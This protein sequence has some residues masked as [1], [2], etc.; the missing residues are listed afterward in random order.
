MKSI[1]KLSALLLAVLM[2]VTAFGTT[3]VYA[4]P[5]INVGITATKVGDTVEVVIAPE[6]DLA[7]AG[8]NLTYTYDRTAF[9]FA[10]CTTPVANSVV[11]NP[12]TGLITCDRA[13]NVIIPAGEPLIKIVFNTTDAYNAG[14]EYAFS[15]NFAEA[16][17]E[18]IE[19]YDWI[20]SD[21]TVTYSEE[22]PAESDVEIVVT[23]V[24]DT[25]EVT[26]VPTVDTALAGINLV[27]TYDR[28][29]F[30]FVSCSSPIASSVIHNPET[31]LI[32][33]DRAENVIVA[34]GSPIVTIV[35]NFAE[36]YVAGTE[37]TFTAI[38]S[39]A[40]DENIEPYAWVEKMLTGTYK[41]DAPST[42]T[43]TWKVEGQEDVTTTVNAGEMPEYPNGTPTKEGN[44]QYTYTFTG[45]DP[46]VVPANADATYTAVFAETV[47]KYTVTFVDGLTEGV[48]T[49]V[50]VEYG[51]AATAP[52][53]PEHEGYT[54]IG[55]DPEDFTN[56][57]ADL[58]VT[59]TYAINK[60]TVTFVDGLTEGV[61]TTVE[62]E[63]G[64]AATAPAAPEHEGYTFIGW[65]PENFTNI[66]ANLTV[67]ATYAINKYT[68]T[69]VDGLTEEVITT[70][71]VEHGAAATAPAAPEHEGYTFIGWNP[72]DFSEVTENMTVTAM[73]EEI[74]YTPVAPTIAAQGAELRARTTEDGKK[75]VRF[76]FEVTF[77]D[78]Y[79]N[80]KG[81][82]YGPTTDYYQITD[83]SVDLKMDNG[84]TNTITA[85]SI[86]SMDK[87]N[88]TYRVT[89][90]VKGIPEDKFDVEFSLVPT[91]TYVMGETT[92]TATCDALKTT[93]N[94]VLNQ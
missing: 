84:T 52:A 41:E 24:G 3:A 51:A 19:N 90:V 80:Y 67:T 60:Y 81:K 85:N 65:D 7:V 88:W 59:A 74:P 12:A 56:I 11:H 63:H 15:V 46:E 57:T 64:A 29:A 45:W 68:V 58:T 20:G 31:G 66:T 93:V 54:F 26:I 73:Y 76:I 61:I 49:T 44:A 25:I 38:F 23:R 27:Y 2:V 28:E 33:C 8:I 42:F 70:V 10:S 83:I 72:E 37:Y 36:G 47:N 43:I 91:L 62:V 92:G 17:D 1:K 16:Y 32:T 30:T 77:N 14:T 21:M 69:F 82:T 35:F 5:A 9:T 94:G 34:A 55:W 79:V 39:E 18:N 4:D 78:S 53:A 6:A 48:I 89:V 86:F 22:A 40:Y 75:D 50:E 71:E 13:E 87:T